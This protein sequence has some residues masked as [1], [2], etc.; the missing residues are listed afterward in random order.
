MNADFIQQFVL[1][2]RDS[3]A[4]DR[5]MV[6]D[7][8]LTLI[9]QINID[10][11]TQRDERFNTLARTVAQEALDSQAAVITN[12]A[13]MILTDTPDTNVHIHTLRMIVA[14]PLLN[15]GVIYYDKLSRQGIFS[16]QKV[17]QLTAFAQHIID[18]KALALTATD[19]AAQFD[20]YLQDDQA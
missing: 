14:L 5:C 4:A 8:T 6:F 10:P 3:L 1:F 2:S 18:Q 7:H 11:A 15:C 19:Y 9:Q 13:R 17:D 12:N 16:R 20:K